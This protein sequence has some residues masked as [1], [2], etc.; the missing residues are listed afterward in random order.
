MA[1]RNLMLDFMQGYQFGDSLN[2]ADRAE[3]RQG[4]LDAQAADTLARSNKLQDLQFEE[5]GKKQE[6]IKAQEAEYHLGQ[7]EKN[8]EYVVPKD[9]ISWMQAKQPDLFKR[10]AKEQIDKIDGIM[11]MMSAGGLPAKQEAV[12]F[13][14]DLYDSQIGEGK[15]IVDLYPGQ[16]GGIIPEL[17]VVG[18]DGK[19]YRAP[20][21]V[22]RGTAEDG[23]NVVKEI[24]MQAIFKDVAMRRQVL[25][26]LH[27]I[28]I[29]GGVDPQAAEKKLAL[30]EKEAQIKQKYEKQAPVAIGK[31]GLYDPKS[32]K[33]ISGSGGAAGGLGGPG[34]GKGKWI[35]GE[36]GEW[37]FL[38]VGQTGKGMGKQHVKQNDDGS[39]TVY[40]EAT[41]TSRIIYPP[42]LAMQKAKAMAE[43]EAEE[44]A[45]GIF[46][47]KPS[48]E[49]TNAR[50]QEIYRELLGGAT[51]GANPSA[52]QATGKYPP[53]QTFKHKATGEIWVA[54][55]NGVPQKQGGGKK[56]EPKTG[57]PSAPR[58]EQGSDNSHMTPEQ[59][60]A[61]EKARS[62]TAPLPVQNP[63][64][65]AGL[66]A[67]N[68]RVRRAAAETKEK[69]RAGIS[70]KESTAEQKEVA[71]L[72]E[73]VGTLKAKKARGALST[74]R[75]QADYEKAVSL[76]LITEPTRR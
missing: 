36:D 60:A 50:A 11:R 40:D 30:A 13:F 55:A 51:P 67:N 34:Y 22:N 4:K 18:K 14:N 47:F 56:S 35:M 6:A 75:D 2:R 74:G 23:D 69:V 37:E 64:M 24:P 29:R 3:A 7:L 1:P 16:N 28:Q 76:G 31:Y 27:G 43:V 54:D 45:A 65:A 53:G 70:A 42:E 32:G 39:T 9:T 19:T 10:P 66:T 41:R 20:M 59:K 58:G 26:L 15:R 62:K 5:H 68:E 73:I 61:A 38:S 72:K 57:Q 33:T 63:A 21:T 71:R 25:G 48:A 12:D 17:E 46:N 44:A 52:P 8:P 49:K